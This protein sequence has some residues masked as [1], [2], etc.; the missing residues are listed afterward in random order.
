MAARKAT[1]ICPVCAGVELRA[2][3]HIVTC[4]KCK[5]RMEKCGEARDFT[6]LSRLTP[7]DRLVLANSDEELPRGR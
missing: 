1:F 3:R 6:R 7:Q 5:V 2:D 4:R